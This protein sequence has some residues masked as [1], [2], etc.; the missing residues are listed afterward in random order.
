MTDYDYMDDADLPVS[1]REPE[2]TI[3]AVDRW[4]IVDRKLTKQ[5][6]FRRPGDRERFIMSLLRYE[7]HVE[8]NAV[9]TIDESFVALTLFTKDL[10]EVS[11]LDKEYAAHADSVFRE[12]VYSS[13]AENF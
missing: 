8:H 10:D 6:Q 5:F 4:R 2:P 12:I 1:P 7:Q 9:I 11:D 3:I 13:S